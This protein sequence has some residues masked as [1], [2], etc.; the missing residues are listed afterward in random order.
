ML[1]SLVQSAERDY[2]AD[3]CLCG[4][5]KEPGKFFCKACYWALPNGIRRRLGSTSGRQANASLYDEAKD[6]LR[7]NT[8]RLAAPGLFQGK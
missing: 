8:G 6:W 3:F 2:N 5:G 1:E 7:I 4:S